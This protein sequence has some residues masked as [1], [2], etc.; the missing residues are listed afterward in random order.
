MFKFSYFII[1][2]QINVKCRRLSS[3]SKSNK[4]T[5]HGVKLTISVDR[6][7]SNMNNLSSIIHKKRIERPLSSVKQKKK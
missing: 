5:K 7:E 3:D 2:L 4:N 1:I 6:K